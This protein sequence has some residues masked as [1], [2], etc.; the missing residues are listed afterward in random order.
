MI[1]NKTTVH[2]YCS[3][4]G[5]HP[6]TTKW[7]EILCKTLNDVMYF[8]TH[9]YN[10]S[11][12]REA[13]DVLSYRKHL[14]NQ[15]TYNMEKFVADAERNLRLALETLCLCPITKSEFKLF[16]ENLDKGIFDLDE[17]YLLQKQKPK[18]NFYRLLR[19]ASNF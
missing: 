7:L 12:E 10:G 11:L 5:Y 9:F 14:L 17:F 3:Q 13:F 2:A 18:L 6:H 4:N 1:E 19:L 16:R 15:R 8:H